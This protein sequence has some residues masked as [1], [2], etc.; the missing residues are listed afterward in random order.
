MCV[1]VCGE[2]LQLAYEALYYT[3]ECSRIISTKTYSDSSPFTEVAESRPLLPRFTNLHQHP[4]CRPATGLTRLFRQNRWTGA[5]ETLQ[6]R[7]TEA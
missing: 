4:G 7:R 3:A 1:C 6:Q 2:R 5:C